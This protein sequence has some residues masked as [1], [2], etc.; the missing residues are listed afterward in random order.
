[1]TRLILAAALAVGLAPAL[2]DEKAELDKFTG[3]WVGVSAVEDGKAV[4]Q[5]QAEAMRLTVH[6][7]KYTFKTAT[8]EAEGTHKLDPT[9][10]PR[11]I[12]A[13][14]TKGPHAGEKMLGIYELTA[15]TFKV[16]FAAPGQADRPT[17]FKSAAGSGHRLL[18][19]KREKR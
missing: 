17:E 19:L 15:D 5:A 9:K 7:E 10:T 18:V 13:V 16:C 14:R 2:G 3:T 1:M 12:E 11:Q 8:T 4:P 6:G